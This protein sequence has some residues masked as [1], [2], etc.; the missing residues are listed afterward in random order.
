MTLLVHTPIDFPYTTDLF[1]TTS[2]TLPPRYAQAHSIREAHIILRSEGNE[3]V[4]EPRTPTMRKCYDETRLPLGNPTHLP[5]ALDGVAHFIYLLDCYNE[6]SPLRGIALEMHRLLGD[7][8]HR[9]PDLSVG[10]DGNMVKGGAV[11]FASEE[12]AKYGFTIRNTSPEDLFPYLFYFDPEDFTVQLWYSPQDASTPPLKSGGTVTLGMGDEPAYQFALE[13]DQLQSSGF[14]KLF[15]A[16][17]YSDLGWIQQKLSPFDP[18]FHS[19]RANPHAEEQL[20]RVPKWDALTVM[21]TM[22]AE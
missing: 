22:T 12:G 20:D 21:L 10:H 4:I 16:T 1:R 19:N 5:A 15:V 8:P 6:A 11:L 9:R 14:L 18:L 3:I 17:E 2:S 13:L 7:F